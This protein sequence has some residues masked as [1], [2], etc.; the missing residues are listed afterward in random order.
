MRSQ[1]AQQVT[2]FAGLLITLC[3]W[4]YAAWEKNKTLSRF[5]HHETRQRDR[6]VEKFSKNCKFNL[7][8]R[9]VNLLTEQTQLTGQYSSLELTQNLIKR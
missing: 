6:R 1:P 5:P 7:P 9:Q 4:L 3:F 8:L 2:P